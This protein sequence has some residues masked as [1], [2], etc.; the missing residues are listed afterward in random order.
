MAWRLY[1]TINSDWYD[2]ELYDTQD[3]CREAANFYRHEAAEMGDGLELSVE[4]F[5]PSELFEAT[6]EEE[7]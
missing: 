1:D 4:P 3:A 2:D 6:F 7:D 5:D